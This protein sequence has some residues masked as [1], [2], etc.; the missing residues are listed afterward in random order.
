MS[1]E[2]IEKKFASI[3]RSQAEIIKKFPKDQQLDILWMLI[4]YDLDGIEPDF[5]S[6]EGEM[7]ALQVFWEMS[8]PLADART[9][10]AINGKKGGIASGKKRSEGIKPKQNEAKRSKTNQ[11]EA[12]RSKGQAEKEKE[13][14]T[15]KEK[16][17]FPSGASHSLSGGAC[18]EG[19]DENDGGSIPEGWTDDDEYS[20]QKQRYFYETR[21][22]F[23]EDWK[24]FKGKDDGS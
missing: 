8:Q 3:Y 10:K 19:W 16:E 2:K 20:F 9:Q 12:K 22:Q 13:K 24:D 23:W 6:E 11:A 15:D 21:M 18:P 7:T 1:E 17:T 4:D 5:G 14:D